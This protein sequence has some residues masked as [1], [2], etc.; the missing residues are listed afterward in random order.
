MHLLNT[1][2]KSTPTAQAPKT[3]E[4]GSG[5]Q[6]ESQEAVDHTPVYVFR[7][8]SEENPRQSSPTTP[9]TARRPP[10]VRTDPKRDFKL[11]RK[12]AEDFIK[13]KRARIRESIQGR[14]VMNED[15]DVSDVSDGD[16][17]I[18][19][20]QSNA[21]DVSE[22]T[23]VPTAED[24]AVWKA[25]RESSNAD[26]RRNRPLFGPR[27]PQ[28]FEV[29]LAPVSESVSFADCSFLK[30]FGEIRSKVLG[31]TARVLPRGS[32]LV[33]V[34]RQDDIATI[35]NVESIV[36]IPVRACIPAAAQ[37]WGR[38][39]GIHPLFQEDDLLEEL[40]A[41]GVEK[42]LRE[43][44]SVK[45][46]IDGKN[47]KTERPSQRIRLLF[48]DRLPDL[49]TIAYESYRVDW[50]PASPLQCL[51]CCKFGH[52]AASCPR[53][54]QRR[55]RK[56]GDLGHE[57][58]ECE[59]KARCIN[60]GG[61]HA[62]NHR[63]CPVYAVHAKAANE[64][65]VN[66]IVSSISEARIEHVSTTP[67]VP[68]ADVNPENTEKPSFAAIVGA[69]AMRK[70]VKKTD[71]GDVVIC[72]IPILQSRSKA[73][74]PRERP[75][76]SKTSPPHRPTGVSTA[77]V[78]QVLKKLWT[79]IKPIVEP[80]LAEH[81]TFAKLIDTLMSESVQK[82]FQQLVDSG[83]LNIPSDV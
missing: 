57:L 53:A 24:R 73:A 50:C 2:Q 19:C 43:K 34:P 48:K 4:D 59:K 49:V 21:E 33:T 65:N 8:E 76:S 66:R 26:R 75:S 69:P 22:W 20:I 54:G 1:I 16:P 35:K 9:A 68:A 27:G 7:A 18:N 32:L 82:L 37:L 83:A 28:G 12:S 31:A 6:L 61:S 17:D 23:R 10:I 56:C 39:V 63:S 79:F 11:Q 80:L 55:C 60:C 41:Q 36:G 78:L 77:G 52:T 38:I 51:T 47:V 74:R 46:V 5:S 30:L 70:V 81:P 25:Q 42:V 58:W 64:R 40:R 45:T 3:V 71:Q 14:R 29:E 15:D 62:A 67:A 72:N 13:D 44:Y